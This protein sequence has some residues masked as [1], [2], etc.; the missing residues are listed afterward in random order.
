MVVFCCSALLVE[1]FYRGFYTNALA[2][3]I[4]LYASAH[5]RATHLIFPNP[6]TV[7]C[8]SPRY[9]RRSALM[10]SLVEALSLYISFPISLAMR[11]FQATTASLSPVFGS[12]S[13]PRRCGF[14]AGFGG[15]NSS[16]RSEEHTS[17]LKSH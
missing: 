16:T 10:V 17:A 6:R 1:V 2:K 8:V 7:I 13:L 15:T 3:C 9:V 12:S 11:C 14:L 4:T 5:H